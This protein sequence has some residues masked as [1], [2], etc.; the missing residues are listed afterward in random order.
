MNIRLS[1]QNWIPKREH[2]MR[3]WETECQ[4]KP[5]PLIQTDTDC[6]A[7]TSGMVPVHRDDHLDPTRLQNVP[8]REHPVAEWLLQS[9]FEGKINLNAYA[10]TWEPKP[11]RQD[12]TCVLD[13]FLTLALNTLILS[14]FYISLDLS[15]IYFAHFSG[16]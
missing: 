15:T 5:I 7:A 6:N 10:A 4:P 16:C 11:R 14:I 9:K 2:M 3:W 12:V 8:L 1:L 13:Q